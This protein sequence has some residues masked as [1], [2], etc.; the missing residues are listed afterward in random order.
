LES[1]FSKVSLEVGGRNTRNVMDETD[2]GPALE[3]DPVQSLECRPFREP[4]DDDVEQS[5]GHTGAEFARKFGEAYRECQ[6][7]VPPPASA[8]GRYMIV[9]R[10]RREGEMDVL[11]FEMNVYRRGTAR[12]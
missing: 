11:R 10:D 7:R 4:A 6:R 12:W 5:D 8:P 3:E 9:G 2:R 1:T